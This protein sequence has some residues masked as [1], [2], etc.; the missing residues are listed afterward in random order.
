[1]DTTIR[2]SNRRV[3]NPRTGSTGLAGSDKPRKAFGSSFLPM[4]SFFPLYSYPIHFSDCCLFSY[5]HTSRYH[6]E[7]S[8]SPARDSRAGEIRYSRELPWPIHISHSAARYRHIVVPPFSFERITPCTPNSRHL[9]SGQSSWYPVEAQ[10]STPYPD[11][12]LSCKKQKLSKR[13]AS[14]PT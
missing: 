10:T 12:S 13:T 7:L 9:S 4:V 3:L 2:I 8:Q 14:R 6:Q 11:Q 5:Q 1:M